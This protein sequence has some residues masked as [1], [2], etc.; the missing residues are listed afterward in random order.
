[1]LLFVQIISN[2]F[3]DI[4]PRKKKSTSTDNGESKKSDIK[5]TK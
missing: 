1:V 3:D 2:P 4:I 5:A